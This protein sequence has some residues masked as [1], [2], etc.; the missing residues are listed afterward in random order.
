MHENDDPDYM[1]EDT[2]DIDDVLNGTIPLDISHEGG[3]FR[4]LAKAMRA[5]LSVTYVMP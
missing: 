1:D 4:E 5:N 2:I 3:E